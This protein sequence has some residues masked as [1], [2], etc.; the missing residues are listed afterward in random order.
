MVE[1]KVGMK[2]NKTM[3]HSSPE[4][5]NANRVYFTEFDRVTF[6]NIG[7]SE[8]D[9]EAI[10]RG[11]ERKIKLLSLTKGHVIVDPENWTMC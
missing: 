7:W 3:T 1:R 8:D 10:V 5:L 6:S 4:Q 9:V 2:Q 11:L